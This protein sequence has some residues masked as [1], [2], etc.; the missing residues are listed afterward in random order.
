MNFLKH[1]KI[2]INIVYQ[3]LVGIGQLIAKFAELALFDP[4]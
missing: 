4:V 2:A 1:D 3:N